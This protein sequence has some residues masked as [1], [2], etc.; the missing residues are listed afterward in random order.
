[1]NKV[2]KIIKIVLGI[3]SLAISYFLKEKAVLING[4]L[5]SLMILLLLLETFILKPTKASKIPN[6]SK[7]MDALLFVSAFI[8]T[9]WTR[10]A[11]MASRDNWFYVFMGLEMVVMVYAV[12]KFKQAPNDHAISTKIYALATMIW[13]AAL[14]FTG[15]D[16]G[17][18][19]L[20]CLIGGIA[21]TESL[22]I[23]YYLPVW[24]ESCN[25]L[26][27]ALRKRKEYNKYLNIK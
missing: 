1:M 6:P 15:A 18:F 10:E 24:D 25:T 14:N 26:F 8:S 9:G 19:P 20:M 5:I 11:A 27:K 16:W 7:Q 23:V 13:L 17:I 21:Y 4:I 3:V 22:L 2:L 12:K